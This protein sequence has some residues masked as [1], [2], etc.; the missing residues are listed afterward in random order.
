MNEISIYQKKALDDYFVF[1]DNHP[2]FF[3]PRKLRMI[4]RKRDLIEEYI[5]KNNTFIGVLVRTPYSIFIVDLVESR[6]IDNK[7]VQYPY[8][9]SFN[10]K[11]IKGAVN[12]VILASIKNKTSKI[13]EIVLVN[14]ERHST[15]EFHLEL[16]RGFGEIGLSG[17][18]NSMKELRE[19]TGYIGSNSY[20]LGSSYTDSGTSNTKVSFYHIPI[21]KRINPN[22]DI[23][24]P[25]SNI[26]LIPISKIWKKIINGEILDSFTIQALVLF[27]KFDKQIK[28]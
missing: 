19:E 10:Q 7:Y 13:D 21:M 16:P 27:E 11:E 4:I 14:Q 20:F 2:E 28:K 8:Q 17:E 3:K 5:R 22:S 23:A 25:I 9:R 1:M 15:G 12:V 26:E 6:D 24:E 18:E